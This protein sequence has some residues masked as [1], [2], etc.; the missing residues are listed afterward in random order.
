MTPRWQIVFGL[1]EPRGSRQAR[2]GV[3]ARQ[4]I[5]MARDIHPIG[6]PRSISASIKSTLAMRSIPASTTRCGY[7]RAT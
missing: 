2:P 1:I 7:R 6:R 4:A 3:V 5:V